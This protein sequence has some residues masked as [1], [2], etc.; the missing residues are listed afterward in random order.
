M[1][2]QLAA[3]TPGLGRSTCARDAA[4]A[5]RARCRVMRMRAP[6]SGIRIALFRRA[7]ELKLGFV[8]SA[9][10]LQDTNW[11]LRICHLSL[12]RS[13]GILTE[14]HGVLY[15]MYVLSD[16]VSDLLLHMQCSSNVINKKVLNHT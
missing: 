14:Y 2:T 15:S 13:V 12:D 11:H 16:H 5:D 10:A 4:P 1:V 6:F 3:A 9:T 7:G 8:K